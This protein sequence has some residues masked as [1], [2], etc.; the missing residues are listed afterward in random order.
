MT[1]RRSHVGDVKRPA[2]RGPRWAELGAPRVPQQFNLVPAGPGAADG[3]PIPRDGSCDERG[4]PLSAPDATAAAI[5]MRLP[6][7]QLNTRLPTYVHPGAF[8]TP[9]NEANRADV[10]I[11]DTG[12]VVLSFSTAENEAGVIRRL[13][14]QLEALAAFDDVQWL[15]RARGRGMA[16]YA[17]LA[18]PFGTLADP[19][20]VY[21]L[22]PSESIIEVFAASLTV[23]AVHLGR[24]RVV[25]WK[26]VTKRSSDGY[27]QQPEQWMGD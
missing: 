23:A 4:V 15:V 25:G 16:G 6:E 18:G 1:D 7:V 3:W 12:S 22:L 2:A 24:A 19:G 10:N 21:I 14:L 20:D 5:A 11:V 9:L 8:S 17:N 13:G 27:Q 26:T